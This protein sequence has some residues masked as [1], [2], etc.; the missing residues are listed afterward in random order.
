L[1]IPGAIE[2]I[3]V[4]TAT[5][6]RTTVDAFWDAVCAG[7]VEALSRSLETG[8]GIDTRDGEGRSALLHAVIDRRLGVAQFLI[9]RGA[10][11]NLQDRHG[12]G[13]L[14]FAAQNYD[15]AM[16][17]LLLKHEASVDLQDEH[18]N[19]PLSTAVFNSRGRG[20]VI[21]LFMG[22]G[23]N[24]HLK[25]KHGVSPHELASI[26]ANYDVAQFLR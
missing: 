17:E 1:R 20:E 23:A 25:N 9:E 12:W 8:V 18:G 24:K 26:I 3:D 15:A 13:A 14:H 10:H 21:K 2:A 16:T 6:N 4:R 19:S 7:D 5:M 11:V 22:H